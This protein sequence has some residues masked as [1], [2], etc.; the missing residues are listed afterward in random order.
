MQ[1]PADPIRI[2]DKEY[3]FDDLP[4]RAQT[5]IQYMQTIDANLDNLD[6]QMDMMK[7]T[8]VGCFNNLTD[9]MEL[10]NATQKTSPAGGIQE[11]PD[12]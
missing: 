1:K 2:G 11:D 10:H 4:P 8:R 6:M 3:K 5:M 12:A 7:I 9:I